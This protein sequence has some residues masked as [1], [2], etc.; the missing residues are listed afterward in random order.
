M[1]EQEEA[2]GA[3]DVGD[4]ADSAYRAPAQKT[5]DE[6]M[7][8]DTEDDSLRKYKATLLGSSTNALPCE[9]EGEGGGRKGGG[10]EL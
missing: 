6:L 3:G 7:N 2:V 9:G 5:V 4:G 10:M 1:A 8:L